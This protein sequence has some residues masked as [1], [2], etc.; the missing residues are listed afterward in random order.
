MQDRVRNCIRDG[1]G[2]GGYITPMPVKRSSQSI[3][4]HVDDVMLSFQTVSVSSLRV[5]GSTFIGRVC[6]PYHP[7]AMKRLNFLHFHHRPIELIHIIISDK[8]WRRVG[9]IVF[10]RGRN[11]VGGLMFVGGRVRG[12]KLVLGL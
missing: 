3:S 5:K 9:I 2:G 6:I 8:H 11:G 1:S 4:S 7:H 10:S 12:I